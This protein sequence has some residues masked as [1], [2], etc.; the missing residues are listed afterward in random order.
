MAKK[1]E[2][3]T[4]TKE[5]YDQLSDDSRF[6]N[7]LECCGVDNWGGYDDAH[8]FMKREDDDDDEE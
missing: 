2:M 4:I 8:D 7:A 6:L 1:K 3:I 5:E